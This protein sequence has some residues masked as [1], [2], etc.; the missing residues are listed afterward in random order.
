MDR[1]PRRERLDV[2]P[3]RPLEGVTDTQ[4]DFMNHEPGRV[5]DVVLCLQVIERLQDRDYFR[6]LPLTGRGEERSSARSGG[7]RKAESVDRPPTARSADR[8]GVRRPGSR[9]ID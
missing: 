2:R 1:I 7:C 5:F 8:P 3:L 4:A 6:A 9:A